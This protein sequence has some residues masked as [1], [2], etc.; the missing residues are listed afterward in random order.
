[1]ELNEFTAAASSE[2]GLTEVTTGMPRLMDRS[3]SFFQSFGRLNVRRLGT[4]RRLK[5]DSWYHWMLSQETSRLLVIGVSIYLSIVIVY[6]GLYRA[7]AHSCGLK[8]TTFRRSFYLSIETITTLGYGVPDPYYN[9]CVG[10][11]FVLTS[12][13]LIGL[14]FEIVLTGVIFARIA[15]PTRRAAT[16]VFSNKAVLREHD[17]KWYFQLQVTDQRNHQLVEAHIR[18]CKCLGGR[19]ICRPNPTGE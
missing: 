10:G 13:L 11:V 2:G 19:T 5:W 8:A 18:L 1:M 3:S 4:T 16:I 7:I 15:R 17:G 6:A 12:Q 9:D 14:I